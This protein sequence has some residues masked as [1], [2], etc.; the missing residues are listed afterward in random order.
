MHRA[1]PGSRSEPAQDAAAREVTGQ[2]AGLGTQ[3][4]ARELRQGGEPRSS[5]RRITGLY[6]HRLGDDL[7]NPALVAVA[8]ENAAPIAHLR[9]FSARG[10]VIE[11]VPALGDQ[12]VEALEK[13]GLDPLPKEALMFRRAFCEQKSATSR[14]M[15][16]FS[17]VLLD[18]I[19]AAGGVACQTAPVGH[20]FRACG[21][22][23]LF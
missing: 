14:K 23:A 4:H 3:G 15:Q 22:A 19:H 21:V 7:S 20:E 18:S 11:G 2:D 9:D 17:N 12:L 8:P 16:K 10:F 6:S 1:G 13:L 5:S